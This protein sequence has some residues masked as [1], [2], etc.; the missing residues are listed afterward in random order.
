MSYTTVRLLLLGLFAGEAV[1]SMVANVGVGA[2]QRGGWFDAFRP[3]R[4]ARGKGPIF[5]ELVS[6]HMT[7]SSKLITLAP[8]L[9]LK[10]AA[11]TL[12]DAKITGAPVVDDGVLIGVL[13]RTDLLYKLA[14]SRSLS[15]AGMGPRSI[16]YM[17]NTLRLIKVEAQC[18]RDAMTTN[19]ISLTPQATMQDAAAI[20]LRRKLNRLMV[21]TES[22]ELKGMVTASDVVRLTL[23]AD[24]TSGTRES[25]L[26]A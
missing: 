4:A 21:A 26:D 1:A 5:N 7:P 6:D 23:E 16:R 14:G 18:V 25:E 3:Q 19:P 9:P 13:S 10:Q 12:L 11:Q 20:M 24:E 2:Q 22:G 17:D 8:E 15:V